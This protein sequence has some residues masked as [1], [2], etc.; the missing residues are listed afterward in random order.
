[1]IFVPL[2]VYTVLYYCMSEENDGLLPYHADKIA[3]PG[4]HLQRP[5]KG[6]PSA[7]HSS[8]VLPTRQLGHVGSHAL[9]YW[10]QLRGVG[11]PM[12]VAIVGVI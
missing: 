8:A 10:D 11:R 6:M 7:I 3:P 5:N 1:M 12:C 9:L 4:Q 2:T